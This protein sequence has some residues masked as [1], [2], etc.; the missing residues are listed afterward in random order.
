ML[1]QIENSRKPFKGLVESNGATQAHD[2]AAGK[3]VALKGI[4]MKESVI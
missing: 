4:V 2:V 1:T 3:F